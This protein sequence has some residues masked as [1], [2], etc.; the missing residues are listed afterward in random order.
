MRINFGGYPQLKNSKRNSGFYFICS[1][2]KEN[3]DK[4]DNDIS[5]CPLCKPFI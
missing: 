3:A 4:A 2:I 5:T 1:I